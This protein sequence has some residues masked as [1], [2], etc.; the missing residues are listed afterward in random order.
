M[1]IHATKDL[2]A[3]RAAALVAIDA[4]A[5]AMRAEIV[6]AR[7]AQMAVYLDKEREALACAADPAPAAATYP[8]CASD[9]ARAG[10]SLHQAAAVIL[11]AAASWR[12]SAVAIEDL[13]LGAKAAARAAT[14]VAAIDAARA[15]VNPAALA[16]R[17]STP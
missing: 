7:P 16:A 15:S 12:A 6:T 2:D 3:I 11:S 14:T 10:L 9:A 4:S 1:K 17:L 8:Y 13:R 5:E